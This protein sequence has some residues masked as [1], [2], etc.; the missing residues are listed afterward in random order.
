MALATHAI[1][2]MS[3]KAAGTLLDVGLEV[4]GRIVELVVALGLFGELRVE[5][6]PRG[7]EAVWRERGASQR[8]ALR[9]GQQS[10]LEQRRRDTEVGERFMLAFLDR[11]DAVAGLEA[12]VPEEGE[13]ALERRRPGA[14][15]LRQ[16]DH[17]IHVGA[18]QE[19][20]AAVAANGYKAADST[21]APH[22]GAGRTGEDL[23]RVRLDREPACRWAHRPGSAARAPGRRQRGR[24]E[25]R[26]GDGPIR[27]DARSAS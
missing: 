15:G 26:R 17:D 24:R 4:V 21:A 2:W 12:D 6:I 14:L 16:E 25:S 11:P 13:K 7:P 3:R 19:F 9:A 20:A 8:T 10:R 22:A 23:E 5:E 18:G 1:V 27:P